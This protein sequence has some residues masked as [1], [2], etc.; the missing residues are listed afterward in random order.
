MLCKLPE[1]ILAGV[2]FKPYRLQF[3]NQITLFNIHI[4]AQIFERCIRIAQ[5]HIDETVEHVGIFR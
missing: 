5:F 1:T 3:L 2:V 4:L